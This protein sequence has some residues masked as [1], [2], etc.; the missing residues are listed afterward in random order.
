MDRDNCFA[1]E[2]SAPDINKMVLMTGRSYPEYAEKVARHLGVKLQVAKIKEFSNDN[3]FVKLPC[4]VRGRDVYIIQ[5]SSHPVNTHFMELCMMVRACVT[6]SAKSVNVITPYAFYSRSEKKDQ[7]RI[8]ITGRL[9]ADFL[10]SAGVT[11]VITLNLHAQAFG[12]FFSV[13]FDQ[14]FADDVLCDGLHEHMPIDNSVI[15]TPDVGGA[16]LAERFSK[17]LDLPLAFLYKKR[18][19]NKENPVI[20]ACAGDVAGKNAI[21]VDDEINTGGSFISAIEYL[22]NLGA[23]SIYGCVIHPAFAPG[24]LKRICDSEISK[25]LVADSFPITEQCSDKLI[26]VSTTELVA[27]AIKQIFNKKSITGLFPHHDRF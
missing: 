22:K 9:C 21:I 18:T 4:N 13:P 20:T 10:E 27:K 17:F 19:D 2:I 8:C 6:S 26:V 23:K 12:A 5:T 16:K 25:L 3:T 7:P 1:A 24:A 14:L 15:V 11:R